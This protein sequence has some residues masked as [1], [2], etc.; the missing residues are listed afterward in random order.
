MTQLRVL[1]VCLFLS[2]ISLPASAASWWDGKWNYRAKIDLNTTSAGAA[3]SEPGG[4]AQVLVRLHS[5]NFNFADAKEDGSDV[6]FIAAD[7]RTP[8]KYHFEKYDGLVDQ[9]ALAWVDVPNLEANAASSVYVYFGNAEATPGGDAKGSYDADNIAVYHF[10]NQGA[11]GN[12]QT[13]YANNAQ[14]PLTLAESAL[15]GSG[16]QLN[17]QAPV[18]V[19]ASSSLNLAAAQP[20]TVSAWIKPTGAGATGIIASLPGALTVGIESGVIYAETPG[21]N[22]ALRTSAGAPLTSEGWAH[23]AV[24]A[25]DNKLAVYVNGAPAG[26]VAAALPLANAGLLIGGERVAAGAAARPNFIG[27]IDELQV[28]KTARPLGLIQAAAHSQ[29]LD[30]RLL[31]FQPVEQRSGDGGHNYFGILFSALTVDAWVVIVILGFMAAISWWV[32]IGKGVFVNVT[33]KAN[34]RF[35]Q[36]FRK[37]AGEYPLHD[38]AWVK[39]AE[40]DGPLNGEKSNLARLLAIGLDE[41]RNRVAAAGGRSVVRTQSIAAIRSALDAAA[42]RESQ[43]LNK[44]MVLLTIAISGGPFL[45]LLGT[46]VGVMITFAAVAAAGDVNINAIAPGIAAALLATVAGLAVA[47][48]ALFGYNYLL[49]RTEAIGADMQV[50]VDELEKRIAEDYAGDAPVPAHL[51][52]SV[53]T[54]SLP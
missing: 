14:A 1:L 41:L 34:E 31:T 53:S 3:V 38:I 47:I 26:E 18:T 30:A 32:M 37:Y 19:P 4:R 5:G 42:V 36:A 51:S 33:S 52:R 10:A 49:S 11:A 16:L 21:A 7:D 6:R 39:G 54:E 35:L 22:G 50:F 24:R 27:L 44:L 46:V 9:V 15:I 48:P 23:I 28:S 20:L 2:L 13:A 45:G 43:R 40:G 12:D 8:L 29:G 25:A 17:G